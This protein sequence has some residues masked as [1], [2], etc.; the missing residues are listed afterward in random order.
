MMQNKKKICEVIYLLKW[1]GWWLGKVVSVRFEQTH[2][3]P[4]LCVVKF[5]ETVMAEEAW[6]LWGQF[7]ITRHPNGVH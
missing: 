1:Q 7:I 3:L 6:A 2:L 4:I 5:D